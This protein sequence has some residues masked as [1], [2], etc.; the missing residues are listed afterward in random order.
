[1]DYEILLYLDVRK[2]MLSPLPQPVVRPL[3]VVQLRQRGQQSCYDGTQHHLLCMLVNTLTIS[4]LRPPLQVFQFFAL[5]STNF[6]KFRNFSDISSHQ[7]LQKTSDLKYHRLRLCHN[8]FPT[9]VSKYINYVI[10]CKVFK[11]SVSRFL[12]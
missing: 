5:V 9:N 11:Y 12:I 4:F 3:V 6:A 1:M 2:I 10:P 8:S 7:N